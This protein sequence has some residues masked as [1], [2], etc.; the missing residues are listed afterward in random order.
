MALREFR[1]LR[2]NHPEIGHPCFLC[3]RPIQAGDEIGHVPQN[4]DG[5]ESGTLVAHWKCIED[6]FN[7]LGGSRSTAPG[8]TREFLKSWAGAVKDDAADSEFPYA[9]QADFIL[10]HGR[11]FEW[12]AVPPAV[13][14]GTARQC[15]R[16]SVRLAIG[17][18]R[19]YTYVERYAIN[20]WVVRHP[21]AHAWRVDL[22]GFVVDTTWDE[23]MDYFGVSFRM[24][25][26]RRIADARRDYGLIDNEE[27]GFP[28]LRGAHAVADAIKA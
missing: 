22:E 17:K 2:G 23:G 4:P 6:E 5:R 9:S 1:P 18:P 13:R 15:F 10:K 25:Y 19:L 3:K 14:M 21:V 8:A 26:V 20:T 28:L 27:M 24:E 7:R 11:A 16:N 12:R